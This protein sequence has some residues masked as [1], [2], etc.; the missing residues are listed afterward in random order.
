VSGI[1]L[2]PVAGHLLPGFGYADK[3]IVVR[4]EK[5]LD[6]EVLLVFG[7]ILEGLTKTGFLEPFLTNCT[8]NSYTSPIQ[9]EV[10]TK[11]RVRAGSGIKVP[12]GN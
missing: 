1:A 11:W 3:L 4:R 9:G 8:A 2:I 12:F 6:L 7:A 10:D 5:G